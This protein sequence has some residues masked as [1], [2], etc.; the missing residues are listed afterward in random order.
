MGVYEETYGLSSS[1]PWAM[2]S[3]DDIPRHPVS[4]YEIVFLIFLWIFIASISKKHVLQNGAMFKIF[5]IGYLSFRFLLDFIKPHYTYSFGLSTIQMVCCAGLIYYHKYIL[6]PKK[7]F[8]KE[9][10]NSVFSLK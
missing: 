3:G 7:L 2:N 10:V 4:L 6:Q 8:K 5:M 1:L 9:P